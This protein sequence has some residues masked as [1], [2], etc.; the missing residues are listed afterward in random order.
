MSKGRGVTAGPGAVVPGPNGASAI[1]DGGRV[2]PSRAP[3]QPL[4]QRPLSSV[5]RARGEKSVIQR[6]LAVKINV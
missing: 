2:R 5:G 4:F 1:E 6:E 3:G